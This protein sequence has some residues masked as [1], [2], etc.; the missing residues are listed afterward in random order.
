MS[1]RI[2]LEVVTPT[3][4]ELKTQADYVVAPTI[5]GMVGILPGHIRLITQLATGVLRYQADGVD[6][7]L[8]VSEGFM[9][10][11]P[12]KVIV[13][14]EAAELGENVD[15]EQA[16]AEKRLAEEELIRSLN[17]VFDF[18]RAQIDL[19]RALA[20]ITVAK[21]AHQ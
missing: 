5:D 18:S 2:S 8:A 17:G 3:K 4:I 14:A 21:K 19:E 16:L 7:Y 10:V 12:T 13:L 6:H 9:E 15:V 11:T 20:K 1:G